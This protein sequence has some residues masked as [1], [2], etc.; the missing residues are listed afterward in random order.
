MRKIKLFLGIF[1]L[2]FGSVANAGIVWDEFFDGD[3]TALGTNVGALQIGTN[4]FFGRCSLSRVDGNAVI[5]DTDS[6]L[7][8][9]D[10]GLRLDSMSADITFLFELEGST[11]SN[12][13]SGL[14]SPDNT[15][16]YEV[17]MISDITSVS[18]LPVD[19]SGVYRFFTG[20]GSASV[21]DNADI[22]W[23]WRMDMEVSAV[24]APAA[25]WLFGIGL[26]GLIGF[27]KQRKAA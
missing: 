27:T 7:F 24:P 13:F 2:L 19:T 22:R 1:T 25:I 3:L 6:G 17:E 26:I 5:A 23:G 12:R 11:L 10:P 18:L 16:L 4:T 21:A 20:G 9:L 14:R 15:L 8:T